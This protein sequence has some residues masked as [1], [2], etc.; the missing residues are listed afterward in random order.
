VAFDGPEAEV[1][2]SAGTRVSR[3]NLTTGDRTAT[4]ELPPGLNDNL[5]VLP[6]GKP[7]LLRRDG[8]RVAGRPWSVVVRAR[9]LADDG[10]TRELYRVGDLTGEINELRL[11]PDG[12][13]LVAILPVVS[14][15]D[16]RFYEGVEARLYDG[17][18][19]KP[20]PFRAD[21]SRGQVKWWGQSEDG[22]FLPLHVKI[23][24]LNHTSLYRLPDGQFH[25]THPGLL[26]TVDGVGKLGVAGRGDI[27]NGLDLYRVGEADRLVTLDL[28]QQFSGTVQWINSDGTL[29]GWGLKDGIVRVA[30]LPKVVEQLMPFQPR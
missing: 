1:L 4:W 5:V 11:R 28:G 27:T 19:G 7:L 17:R 26:G 8:P 23:G 16:P 14:R 25:S 12:Q 15:T 10:T 22:A 2:V 20:R 13:V 18:T 24:N 29:A 9:E 21:A 6:E 30:N 3:W